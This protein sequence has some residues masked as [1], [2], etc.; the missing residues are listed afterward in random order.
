[1]SFAFA[2]LSEKSFTLSAVIKDAG[3]AGT[4]Y[5]SLAPVRLK[6][7]SRLQYLIGTTRYEII[8]SA[9]D[10]AF[11]GQATVKQGSQV[12]GQATITADGDD[13]YG[14][15]FPVSLNSV[16]G[17]DNI[18]FEFEVTTPG[19]AGLTVSIGAALE[20]LHPIVIGA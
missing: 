18:N 10:S 2:N 3:T 19:A 13:G 9:P 12:L 1:M 6:D 15:T 16:Q 14:G 7:L 20:I 4:V 17:D 8:L 5:T 11:V